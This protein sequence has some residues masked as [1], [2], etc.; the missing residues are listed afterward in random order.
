MD[1]SQFGLEGG[2][3]PVGKQSDGLIINKALC[4]G[5]N[6]LVSH[7][8]K[9]NWFIIQSDIRQ[10]QFF[11]YRRQPVKNC[12]KDFFVEFIE[13]VKYAKAVINDISSVAPN[14]S[15]DQDCSSPIFTTFGFIRWQ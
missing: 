4:M 7:K 9:M 11:N 15:F 3:N 14:P 8:C 1:I 2:V 6:H 10:K 13:G 12:F 5:I